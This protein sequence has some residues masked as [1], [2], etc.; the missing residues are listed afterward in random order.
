MAL[1]PEQVEDRLRI[2]DRDNRELKRLRTTNPFDSLEVQLALET[3]A[4]VSAR[5]RGAVI[6]LGAFSIHVS[7]PELVTGTNS[8]RWHFDDGLGNSVEEI[9]STFVVPLD[10]VSGGTIRLYYTMASATS[11][12]VR[13]FVE[14]ESVE[15]GESL[16]S[17]GTQL[18]IN[19][20]VQGTAANL[21]VVDFDMAGAGE[22]L[23]AGDCMNVLVGRSGGNGDDDAAGDALLHAVVLRYTA[24]F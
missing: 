22:V 13:W 11:G 14:L 19:D 15:E 9:L 12:D 7:T 18:I 8:Q 20:T 16:N 4:T 3:G 1:T 21:G 17:A 6:A 24:F 10:Y 2:L 5:T 23:A